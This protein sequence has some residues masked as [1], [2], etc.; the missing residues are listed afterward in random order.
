MRSL[1]QLHMRVVTGVGARILPSDSMYPHQ[2][3][4]V[5]HILDVAQWGLLFPVEPAQHRNLD[6]RLMHV[7]LQ[8]S[9][10]IKVRLEHAQVPV[11]GVIGAESARGCLT[12]CLTKQSLAKRGRGD[13]REKM[14]EAHP[15]GCGGL[16]EK[17]RVSPTC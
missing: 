4:L 5:K 15:S 7:G 14:R 13:I 1:S 9:G 17:R 12:P 3:E 11:C 6:T 2:P 8:P 10:I 16:C